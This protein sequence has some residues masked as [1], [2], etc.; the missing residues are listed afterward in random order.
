MRQRL[1]VLPPS[2][3]V[4]RVELAQQLQQLALRLGRHGRRRADLPTQHL[5]LFTTDRLDRRHGRAPFLNPFRQRR[6]YGRALTV[7]GDEGANSG[8]GERTE[9]FPRERL[10]ASADALRKYVRVYAFLSRDRHVRDTELERDYLCGK[11]L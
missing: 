6:N 4:R 5:G 11:G 2:D 3:R 1:D 10:S 8:I 9:A 7:N